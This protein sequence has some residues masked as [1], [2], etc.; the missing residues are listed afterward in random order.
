MPARGGGA[1]GG[2]R[3]ECAG[4]PRLVA[5]RRVKGTARPSAPGREDEGE[6]EDGGFRRLA[7]A[8]APAFGWTAADFLRAY[9][10]NQEEA[11][12]RVLEADPVAEAVIEFARQA[13]SWA[14]DPADPTARNRVWK[15]TASTLLT[16][17]GKLV[18]E[19]TRRERSWPKDATRLAGC[20]RRAAPALRTKVIKVDFSRE[21]PDLPGGRK[22]EVCRI[23]SITAPLPDDANRNFAGVPT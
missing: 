20:L 5:R 17:I 12:D 2:F 21:R 6:A 4:D 9:K 19:D 22:G 18:P 8:A 10:E 7:A 11:I 14:A 13:Y 1:L 3:G 16:E 15:A 23:I